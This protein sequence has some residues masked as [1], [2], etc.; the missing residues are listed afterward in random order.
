MSQKS[1]L[2]TAVTVGSEFRFNTYQLS[3]GSLVNV[4]TID[5]GG[6]ENTDL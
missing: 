3:E 2:M 4:T 1:H 6:H 5:T